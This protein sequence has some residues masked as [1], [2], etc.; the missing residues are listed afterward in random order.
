M[1]VKR[2]VPVLVLG[3]VMG[4]GMFHDGHL[5]H[6][7]VMHAIAQHSNGAATQYALSAMMER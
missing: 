2:G 1:V 6:V 4:A 7:L 3:V 5:S